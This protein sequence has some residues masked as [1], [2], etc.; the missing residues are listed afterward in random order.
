MSFNESIYSMTKQPKIKEPV[1]PFTRQFGR[2]VTRTRVKKGLSQENL[3]N[4]S[5]I[6]GTTLSNLVNGRTDPKLST[7][8]KICEA[9]K[10]HP[11]ELFAETK[12]VHLEYPLILQK[13]DDLLRY[14]PNYILD[15]ALKQVEAL[16]D[17]KNHQK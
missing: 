4:D 5:K 13:L 11:S 17:V 6:S 14:E 2:A 8:E 16:L 12:H 7:I 10:I 15:A 1:N 3:S 9:M